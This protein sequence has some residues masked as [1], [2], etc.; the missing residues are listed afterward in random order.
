MLQAHEDVC[1]SIFDAAWLD[2]V[3]SRVRE[4]AQQNRPH[5]CHLHIGARISSLPIAVP[6]VPRHQ[7]AGSIATSVQQPLL[8]A[9]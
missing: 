7:A 4:Q 3:H 9:C 6:P 8:A 2:G 1:G 5:L